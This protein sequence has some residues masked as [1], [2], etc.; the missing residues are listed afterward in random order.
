MGE[1]I[2]EFVEPTCGSHKSNDKFAKQ[3]VGE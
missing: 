3:I 1:F 2:I